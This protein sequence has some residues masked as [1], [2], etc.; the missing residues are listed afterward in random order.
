MQR[1]GASSSCNGAGIGTTAG[2]IFQGFRFSL[3]LVFRYQQFSFYL[4]LPKAY[5]SQE[6]K[7]YKTRIMTSQKGGYILFSKEQQNHDSENWTKMLLSK[8][9]FF[10]TE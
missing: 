8:Y 10:D 9:I 4:K 7:I 5:F 3:N 1:G 2:D 6:T